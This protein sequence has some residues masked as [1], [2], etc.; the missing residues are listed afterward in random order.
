[1]EVSE[2][3]KE[4]LALIK[5]DF[6]M[7]PVRVQFIK[8][9]E[10]LP[11]PSGVVSIKRG[12]ELELPRWQVNELLKEGCVDVKDKR[13]EL[14]EVNLYHYRE[15]RTQG[16]SA[17][18]QLPQDFYLRAKELAKRLDE[19]IRKNPSSMLLRDREMLEKN[20][21]ELADTR[22]LKILRLAQAGGEEYRDKLTPEEVIIYNIVRSLLESWREYISALL[23]GDNVD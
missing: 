6:D 1:M 7:S 3:I 17:P 2:R 16:A 4:R 21:I 9:Y 19:S 23:R 20:I 18:Q 12:D 10:N 11:L 15:K 14:D 5:M 8:D 13:L 22:L